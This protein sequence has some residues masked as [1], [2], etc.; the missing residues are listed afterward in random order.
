MTENGIYVRRAP[1]QKCQKCGADISYRAAGTKWCFD[2]AKK[3]ERE[4]ARMRKAYIKKLEARD[5][6]ATTPN[7]NYCATYYKAGFTFCPNCGQRL[8]E[9]K[10]EEY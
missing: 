1:G 7:C 3:V 4:Q 10:E 5:V 6:V 2:C 8:R 9:S